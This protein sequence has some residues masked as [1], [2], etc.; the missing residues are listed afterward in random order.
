MKVREQPAGD[1]SH[2][3]ACG[4]SETVSNEDVKEY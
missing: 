1:G 4:Y 3:Q 2:L